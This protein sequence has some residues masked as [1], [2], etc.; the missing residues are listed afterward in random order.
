MAER[1]WHVCEHCDTEWSN[2]ISAAMCCDTI[3]N[4]LDDNRPTRYELG[5]D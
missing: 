5:Y 3:S 4:D 1:E 2:P